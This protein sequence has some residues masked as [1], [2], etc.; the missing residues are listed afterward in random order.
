MWTL[1]NLSGKEKGK[2]G[3]KNQLNLVHEIQNTFG[4]S[5]VNLKVEKL[6][7]QFLIILNLAAKN[8]LFPKLKLA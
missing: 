5:I 8:T 1:N 4:F 2:F 3:N 6:S 7:F